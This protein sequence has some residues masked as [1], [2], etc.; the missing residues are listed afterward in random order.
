MYNGYVLIFIV[1]Y[2]DYINNK[3]GRS[4]LTSQEIKH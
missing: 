2:T 1:K 3:M 4:S